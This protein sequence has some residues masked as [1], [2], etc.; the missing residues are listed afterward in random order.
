MLWEPVWRFSLLAQW[1]FCLPKLQLTYTGKSWFTSSTSLMFHFAFPGPIRAR[2]CCWPMYWIP[3]WSLG[4]ISKVNFPRMYASIYSFTSFVAIASLAA[5]SS[6]R[7]HFPS[8]YTADIWLIGFNLARD[9]GIPST[10]RNRDKMSVHNCQQTSHADTVASLCQLFHGHVC[11]W[12]P[13]CDSQLTYLWYL[14]WTLDTTSNLP[15]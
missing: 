15:P 8:V 7:P 1:S 3:E 10:W 11:I 5:V 6:T 9:L 14:G 13:E 4:T 2:L 12:V